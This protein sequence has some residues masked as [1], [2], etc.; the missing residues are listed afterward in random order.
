M[1]LDDLVV[2]AAE[3]EARTGWSAKPEGLCK[4]EICVPAKGVDAGE[5]RLDVSV[6]SEK[7]GMP[8]VHDSSRGVLALG[9][10]CLGRS[11]DTA[12]APELD[13][14]DLRTGASNRFSL[15]S[16]HGRK[17]LLVAW[18]SW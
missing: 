5:G 10:A 13:L 1:I 2:D 18:A 7:L 4:G 3:F 16:L 17:V 8:I 14:P 6:L 12:V 15:S 9:P 11:L